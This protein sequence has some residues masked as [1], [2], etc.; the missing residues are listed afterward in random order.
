MRGMGTGEKSHNEQLCILYCYTNT[1]GTDNL[2][3]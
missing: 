1:V 2:G 3:P